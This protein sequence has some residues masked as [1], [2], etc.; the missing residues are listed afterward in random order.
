MD[1]YRCGIF[2]ETVGTSRPYRK[3]ITEESAFD[4]SYVNEITHPDPFGPY[5]PR[6]LEILGR[7]YLGSYY[8]SWGS[9]LGGEKSSPM[10]LTRTPQLYAVRG[11]P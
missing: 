9:G 8:R 6:M 1:R 10:D 7:G 11:V 4:Y 3:L 2:R 5:A